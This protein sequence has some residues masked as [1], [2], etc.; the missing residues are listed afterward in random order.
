M[1]TGSDPPLTHTKYSF[2]Y[3]NNKYTGSEHSTHAHKHQELL[4][5][6]GVAKLE[7]SN[8]KLQEEVE[9]LSEGLRLALSGKAAAE[10]RVCEMMS[11][12]DDKQETIEH[13]QVPSSTPS[14]LF[15]CLY[16]FLCDIA[17][18]RTLVHFHG[19]QCAI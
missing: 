8:K 10:T 14:P 16:S 15:A 3:F 2:Q 11:D 12:L 17:V 6:S 9:A 13:L 4:E 1:A 5:E 7:S 18:P 19:H